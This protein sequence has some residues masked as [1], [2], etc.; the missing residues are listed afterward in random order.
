MYVSEHYETVKL[1]L[2]QSHFFSYLFTVDH[3]IVILHAITN[4]EPFVEGKSK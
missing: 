1:V 4:G 3:N 2:G